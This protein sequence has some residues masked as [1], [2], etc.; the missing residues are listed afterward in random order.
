MISMKNIHRCTTYEIRQELQRRGTTFTTDN[1]H[2]VNHTVLLQ[3]LVH[4]LYHEEDEKQQHKNDIQHYTLINK[5]NERS[6]LQ[7]H[8]RQQRLERKQ[9]AIRRSKERQMLDEDYFIK[10]K[11]ANKEG[12][13]QL[14]SEDDESDD[15]L[16][17]VNTTCIESCNDDTKDDDNDETKSSCNKDD[18]ENGTNPFAIRFRPKIGGR[19]T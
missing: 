7:E 8:Q 16:F 6:Q 10:K 2:Y 17:L 19:S 14:N 11:I 13:K 5:E 18:E 15:S 12:V 9:Q 3:R 4:L 1:D